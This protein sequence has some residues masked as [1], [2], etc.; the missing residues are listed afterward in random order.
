M[1]QLPVKYSSPACEQTHTSEQQ[2]KCQDMKLLLFF[3]RD[4]SV[5]SWLVIKHLL[6]GLP[7]SIYHLFVNGITVDTHSQKCDW[8]DHNRT[9]QYIEASVF[10]MFRST[11]LF[12]VDDTW[13][14]YKALLWVSIF[15]Y[16]DNSRNAQDEGHAT[17]NTG[18]NRW[19]I[20]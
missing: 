8:P 10:L 13:H 2:L 16:I 14:I 4:N 20:R 15:M 1:I 6:N 7:L 19:R 11:E 9:I 5:N 17:L 18:L 3:C 12:C